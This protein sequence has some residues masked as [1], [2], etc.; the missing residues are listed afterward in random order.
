[1]SLEGFH[2]I[3]PELCTCGCRAPVFRWLPGFE[4]CELFPDEQQLGNVFGS[5]LAGGESQRGARGAEG[6]AMPL[7]SESVVAE[8]NDLPF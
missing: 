5:S 3:G 8:C 4:Q 7:Q 1:M 6:R 2:W